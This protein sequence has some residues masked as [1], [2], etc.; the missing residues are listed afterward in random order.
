VQPS[1]SPSRERAV[2]SLVVL[3]RLG[4]LVAVAIGA[5][6]WLLLGASRHAA[7]RLDPA[8]AASLASQGITVSAPSTSSVPTTSQH[9]EAIAFEGFPNR[10]TV[11]TTVLAKVLVKPNAAL[12]CTCWVVSSLLGPGLPPPGGP[13]GRKPPAKQF[14]SWMRYH[15]TFVNAQSGKFEF[16]VESYIPFQPSPIASP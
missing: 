16:A 10:K 7:A 4:L 14:E 1:S 5:T 9:A 13:P 15:V 8:I 6:V 12:N 2:V 11:S 3:G